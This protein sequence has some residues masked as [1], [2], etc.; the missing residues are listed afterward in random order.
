MKEKKT[1]RNSN[2]MKEKYTKQTEFI[3]NKYS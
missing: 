1:E 3:T 2:I